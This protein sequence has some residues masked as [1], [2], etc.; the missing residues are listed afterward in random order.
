M[1]PESSLPCSQKPTKLPCPELDQSSPC[2]PQSISWRFSLIL[3]S[4]LH[5]G[6][7]SGLFPSVFPT[8]ILYAPLLCPLC[9]PCPTIP[10]FCWFN[11]PIADEQYKVMELF[12]MHFPPFSSNFLFL[13]PEY[14]PQHPPLQHSQSMFL[15]QVCD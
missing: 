6:R 3:S 2:S 15:P 11:H 8:K 14:L 4:H 12:I 1:E 9:A 10:R 5:L 7:P 13:R